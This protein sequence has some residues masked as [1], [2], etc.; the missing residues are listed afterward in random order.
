M[1]RTVA[2]L[3]V[4]YLRYVEGSISVRRQLL[5]K[6]KTCLSTITEKEPNDTPVS[7]CILSA[8]QKGA[9]ND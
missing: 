2:S 5:D 4:E 9:R 6:A 1:L 3:E 7:H 8:S